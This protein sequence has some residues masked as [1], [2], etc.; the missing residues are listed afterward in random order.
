MTYFTAP[1]TALGLPLI[2][3]VTAGYDAFNGE[4]WSEVAEL[5]WRKRDGSRGKHVSPKVWDKIDG[6][7]D[8]LNGLTE[9]VFDHL[10]HERWERET[11]PLLAVQLYQGGT[12]S[13]DFAGPIYLF[14][15]E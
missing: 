15:F 8:G 3:V 13:E 9:Q 2:A 12:Q 10:E 5:F 6:D 7:G 11:L 4:S 14:D 1:V